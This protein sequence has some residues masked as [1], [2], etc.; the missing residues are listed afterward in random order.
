MDITIY[1]GRLSGTL[2]AIP[3]KSQ[4]HRLLICA[5]FS[6]RPTILDCPQTNDDIEA[7]AECL[8]ALGAKI[9][10]DESGYVVTPITN[11]PKRAVLNCRE[12]GSTLRFLLP[13]VCALGVEATIQMSGRLPY[14]PLS[15]LW[16]EL[17]QMGI[18]L[19]RPTANTIT[20]SGQLRSGEYTISGSVSSQFIT[21]LLL[22]TALL[23]GISHIMVKGELQSKP[24][25]DITRQVLSLFGVSSEENMI[26]GHRPLS[27]PGH[28]C[29]EGDWSNA[30][31]FLVANSLGSSLTIKNLD[32]D[33]LQGDRAIAAIIEQDGQKPVISAADIPDLVPIMAVLFGAKNG[34]E[35]TDIQR[36]RIKESDRVASVSNMMEAFGIPT[37]STESTLTIGSGCF[38]SCTVDAAGDHRIAMAAAIAATVADGSVT[39]LGAECVAKSYPAF[40]QE[41]K[42]LGGNYEQHIR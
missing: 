10:R 32:P 7:T 13:V 39:I 15:P 20:V 26:C 12:S 11:L 28:V 36:L 29:V 2:R 8:R 9:S 42:R 14:R 23:P 1:P 31:F 41:F 22:A 34:A 38:H 33:S 6:D 17:E 40:W 5:A 37:V 19:S 3:S 16:E 24:Y 27:S 21:G 30:A 18:R 4:A 35:F 25:V